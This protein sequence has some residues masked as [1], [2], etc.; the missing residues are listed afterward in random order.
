MSDL[1]NR[2]V[3]K[4]NWGIDRMRRNGLPLLE[5]LEDVSY[6][7]L[8]EASDELAALEAVADAAQEVNEWL[9]R[10]NLHNTGH[11]RHLRKSLDALK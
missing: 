9:E 3:D 10:N 8:D 7:E 6:G 2:L 5:C 1:L 4:N 11:G